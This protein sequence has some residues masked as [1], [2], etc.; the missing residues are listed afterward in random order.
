MRKELKL[1]IMQRSSEAN[2]I[3]QYV[4]LQAITAILTIVLKK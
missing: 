3:I 2:V 1:R 4:G